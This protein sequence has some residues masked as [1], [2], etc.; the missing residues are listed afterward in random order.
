MRWVLCAGAL[1]TVSVLHALASPDSAES[2]W[3]PVTDP[4][5]GRHGER[6]RHPSNR[7]E[8]LVRAAN[9]GDRQPRAAAR[10]HARAAR[11]GPGQ[12]RPMPE[13]SSSSVSRMSPR[14]NGTRDVSGPNDTV[15]YP[16]DTRLTTG[17]KLVDVRP[18]REATPA[19]RE[20]S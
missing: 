15:S 1:T 13:A 18:V 4:L 17:G 5:A 16:D 20:R 8:M 9:Q 7:S 6:A 11:P 14:R 12:S 10:D 2:P 3:T 19:S